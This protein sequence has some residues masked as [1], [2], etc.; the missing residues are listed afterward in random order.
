MNL[1]SMAPSV[2]QVSKYYLATIQWMCQ[3]SR[4]QM[5]TGLS[6]GGDDGGVTKLST[7]QVQVLTITA[8]ITFTAY[9]SGFL[10]GDAD[11]DGIVTAADAS[12]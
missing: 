9:Y 2:E 10:K 6:V 1:A 5:V 12:R 11:G 7:A 8:P 4:Q 3:T